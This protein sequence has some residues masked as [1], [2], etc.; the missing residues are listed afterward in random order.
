MSVWTQLAALVRT[1]QEGGTRFLDRLAH[2]VGFDREARRAVVFTVSMIALS[3]KMAK[4]DGV[5]TQDEVVAFQDLFEIPAR[6]FANVRRLFDL[7]KQ[8]VAGF[9]VYAARLVAL[10][11]EDDEETKADVLD[12]LFHI[13]AA[14]G[15]LHEDELVFLAQVAKIFGVSSRVFARIKSA[16]TVRRTNPYTV[17]G[18]S[19]DASDVTVRQHYRRAAMAHHPDRMIARGV[20]PAFLRIANDRLAAINAAWAEIAAE[21]GL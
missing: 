11:S 4:A 3:A 20:P 6:E 5:V 13:A 14:D 19:P 2:F 17:L 9:E 15:V 8:D 7:T 12:G 21:R 16:H 10:F 18:V 1:T